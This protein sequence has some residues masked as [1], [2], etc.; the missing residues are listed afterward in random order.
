MN[1]LQLAQRTARECGI[2]GTGPA[3]VL[4]QTGEAGRI[5]NWVNTAWMDI[6]MLHQDWDWLRTSTSFV[7]VASQAS[8]TP[9]QAGTTNFGMWVRDSFR[10]YLTATGTDAEVYMDFMPYEN[11][12]N[13][14]QFG[15]NRSA[16]SQPK[17]FTI[18]PNKSV[19]LGPVPVV[20]YTVTGDYFT[21]PTEMAA[22]ATIPVMPTHFQ[23]AII[24]RAMMSYGAF[25]GATEVYQRGE[26][27]YKKIIRRME[28]D[29]L[30]EFEF[31]DPLV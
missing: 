27:E 14:Y 30:P 17:F 28:N 4:S 11:W 29:R 10:N 5:V 3:S 21:C 31:G 26:T 19:G 7:T 12:R 8:Y 22:D 9:A 2:S 18:L 24:Y 25:E 23:M 16:T 20:G 1:F 6:Q 15:S 13:V